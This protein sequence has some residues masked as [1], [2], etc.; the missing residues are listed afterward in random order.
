MKRLGLKL[1]LVLALVLPE[2]A[3]AQTFSY[4]VYGDVLAGFRKTGT[5][6]GTYEM[7]VDL[8]SVTNFLKL[9]MGSTI[10]IT[11]FTPSQLTYAFSSGYGNLQWS[12]FST[13]P[14]SSSWV[15][16]LGSFPKDTLWYTLPGT[17]VTT[18][19]QPPVRQS[20]SSQTSPKDAMYGVGSDGVSIS[21]GTGAN[22]DNTLDVIAE[23][24]ANFA[25][26]GYTLSDLIGNAANPADGDFGASGSPLPYDVENITP[27]SFTSA[28]RSDFY[29]VCPYNLADPITGL[30]N[31]TPYFVGYFILNPAGTMT[32]TRASAVTMPSVGTVTSTV[33]NGFSPLQVVFSNTA[34]GTITSWVWNFGNGVIITNSTGANVTNTYA[35]AGDY[36]VTLTVTGPGGSSTNTLSN[37]IVASPTPQIGAAL[38]GGK[39]V[40]S[41]TNCPAGVQYRILNTTNLALASWN[42]VV[43]NTFLSNS[44]FSYTNSTTNAASFFRLISP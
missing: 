42:P 33:T 24:I 38:V 23:N 36:T 5:F 12:V 31:L 8:G 43:T 29:Q 30:T 35:T 6:A 39:F 26:E 40:L 20:Y 11:N 27:N 1:A 25:S 10:S 4:N 22:I 9:S 34:S 28:Q 16:P 17:S 44:S 37:F 21:A 15:T 18:Q 2:L 19:T 32:F 14:N 3:G 41:G 13:F 7:V